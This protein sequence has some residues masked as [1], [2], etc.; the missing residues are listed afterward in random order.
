[1]MDTSIFVELEEGDHFVDLCC[2]IAQEK[3]AHKTEKIGSLN[4]EK[5]DLHLTY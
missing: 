2:Y 3:N 4:S 1:M 5:A